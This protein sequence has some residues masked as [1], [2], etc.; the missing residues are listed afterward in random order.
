MARLQLNGSLTIAKSSALTD[1][2]KEAV[3]AA[4]EGKARAVRVQLVDANGNPFNLQGTL[5]VS[6]NGSL[7]ARFSAR[8]ECFE[9]IE[10]DAKPEKSEQTVDDLASELLG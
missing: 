1:E 8:T 3:L 4:G 2:Q 10:V 5:Y 6:K 7:T 9:L